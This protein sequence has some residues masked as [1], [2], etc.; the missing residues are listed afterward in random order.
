MQRIASH[1]FLEFSARPYARMSLHAL[2]N[3]HEFARDEPIRTAA[4]ILLDYTMVKFALSS[5]RGRRV[6]PFRRHQH[7]INHQDNFLNDLYTERG[8]Q[9]NGFFMAYTGFTDSTGKPAPFPAGLAF[10][11]LI[12]ATAT[13]RPPQAAYVLAMD[14]DR[15]NPPYLHRFYHGTRPQLAAALDTAESGLEIYYRSPSFL[16]SVGGMF[17]NSGYGNDEVSIGKKHAWEE[18]SRAQA[19]TLIP[20]HFDTLF[21]DLIRFE[22]YPDLFVDPFAHNPEGDNFRTSSVN[23]GVHRGLAAG[24]NLRPSEKMTTPDHILESS[25]TLTMHNGRLLVAWQ[26]DAEKLN[27]IMV[28]ESKPLKTDGKK[29]SLLGVDGIEGVERSDWLADTTESAPALA[30]HDGM[31][32]LAWRFGLGGDNHLNL[33]FSWFL[34]VTG[35]P[36][37]AKMILAESSEHGPALASHAGRLFLAWTGENNEKLNVAP[38]GSVE[39]PGTVGPLQLVGKVVHGD[40][41]DAAPALTSHNGRLV[42]AWKGSGN[43]QLN[44]AFSDDNGVSFK[45]K[46]TLAEDSSHGPALASHNGV[47]TMAWKGSG[48]NRL[49]VA[50][51]GLLGTTTGV[52]RFVLQDKVVLDETSTEA[53]ALTS[54]DD[55]LF[56]A[57]KGEHNDLLNLRVSRDG[58][59]QTGP[60]LFSNLQQFGFFLAAYRTPPGKRP[61]DLDTPLSNLAV[62]YAMEAKPDGMN[63]DQFKEELKTH[64]SDLPAR[65]DYGG[66]YHFHT[67]DNKQFS[68]WFQLT[69][70][71]YQ[72]RIVDL[73]EPAAASD[74]STL[75]LV[76]GEYMKATSPE[77]HDGKIEISYPGCDIPLTLDFSDAA[78]PVRHDNAQACPQPLLDRA[79]AIMAY[80]QD[81]ISKAQAPLDPTNPVDPLDALRTAVEVFR[82]FDPPTAILSEYLLAYEQAIDALIAFLLLSFI[83]P[84]DEMQIREVQSLVREAVSVALVASTA[85]GADV[86]WAAASLSALSA[87]LSTARRPD[88]AAL[89]QQAAVDVLMGETPPVEKRLEYLIALAEG[90]H[91]LI[92]RLIANQQ[93]EQAAVLVAETIT[94]YRDY[95]GQPSADVMRVA[96]DL[97]MLQKQLVAPGRPHE[98]VLVQQ[99]A[100]DMLVGF[101]PP[102][103]KRLEYLIA[104][105][106][107]RH[108]LVARLIDD[109]QV[110]QA[111]ALVVETI[112][113]YRDYA[114]EPGADVM[115]VRRDLSELS[116]LLTA[117]GRPQEA[118][119]AKLALDAMA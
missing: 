87:L 71:K 84:L 57:W 97:S 8:E 38:V 45:G 4:Q 26:G 67:P 58:T 99:A 106:E 18:T 110:E 119:L 27:I 28:R 77:G 30:S 81:R 100:V 13:Y 20:T 108:N 85:L 46:T 40:S 34:G 21:V 79:R 49:N 111:A 114:G 37:Q 19:T 117:V 31:I 9:V 63:F 1:D 113:T 80:A 112:A 73:S 78:H 98:A 89:A 91:N 12:S 70:N 102:V 62:I 5:N 105:A 104:L 92:V 116:A 88:E 74:L 51:V 94:A 54:R 115:R 10:T 22:P 11:A 109:Q 53:P 50:R 72:A 65:F 47:L 64:N 39:T 35:I 3:L 15:T 68:I 32:V 55:Q 43:N 96:A 48:N 25:P 60:W 59:F 101:M 76:S 42:L 90:R 82:D 33:A 83:G 16:L 66:T 56:L 24:A 23:I 107:S 41:S 6:N 69:E 52:F 103:E 7:Q 75:P 17:L 36:F 93:V 95:V 29:T 61:E 44:L 2:Y 14:P 118:T 86:M